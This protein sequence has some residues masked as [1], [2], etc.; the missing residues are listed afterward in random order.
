[1]S[2]SDDIG[3]GM[4]AKTP[5]LSSHK[6]ACSVTPG[7]SPALARFDSD[8]RRYGPDACLAGARTAAAP[9]NTGLLRTSR[10]RM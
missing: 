8:A 5:F 2:K 6:V 3:R 4:I 9:P 7:A 10:N 1:M